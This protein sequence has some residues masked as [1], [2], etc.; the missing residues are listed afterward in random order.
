MREIRLSGSE[1]GGT[2]VLPTP[3]HHQ[4]FLRL[5]VPRVPEIVHYPAVYA[6]MIC[7]GPGR[8]H[9]G[10]IAAILVDGY[11]S[12]YLLHHPPKNFCRGVYGVCSVCLG[13]RLLS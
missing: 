6:P 13:L 5:P 3:I 12:P 10:P 8:D 4:F 1:G 7:N 11:R 9:R 2:Q